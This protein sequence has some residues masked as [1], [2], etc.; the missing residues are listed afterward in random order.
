[1]IFNKGKNHSNGKGKVFSIN[2]AETGKQEKLNTY[3]TQYT[4]MFSK[5]IIDLNIK[6]KTIKHL[7]EN[8]GELD[9]VAH[10]CNPRF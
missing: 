7:Q 4:Q 8:I 2:G 9:V 6:V 5:W 10:A 1:L 3:L